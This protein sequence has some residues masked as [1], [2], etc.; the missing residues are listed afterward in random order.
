M[1]ENN[2]NSN[3]EQNVQNNMEELTVEETPVV[4]ETPSVPVEP[5][6]APKKKGKGLKVF[7]LIL[8]ILLVIGGLIFG[9]IKLFKKNTT[10]EDPF[11]DIDTLGVTN[12]DNLDIAASFTDT[13][14]Y[15]YANGAINKDQYLLQLAYSIFEPN[16]LE[17]KYKSLD[18]DYA[19]PRDL[20]EKFFDLNENEV[21][22]ETIKYIFG[23]YMLDFV[24]WDVDDDSEVNKT[25]ANVYDGTIKRLNNDV[26]LYGIKLNKAKLSKEGHFII[27]YSTEGTN[28]AS[29]EAAEIY[30]SYLEE[31]IKKYKKEYGLDFKF[32][33][34][35]WDRDLN[36][37]GITAESKAKKVLEANGIDIKYLD[38]AFPIYLLNLYDSGIP[39]YFS[40]TPIIS[41]ALT[42][43]GN[44]LVHQFKWDDLELQ[45]F[46]SLYGTYSFPYF[47]INS[48]EDIDNVKTIIAHELF[49]HYQYYICGNGGYKA[50]PSGVFTAETT[51]DVASVKCSGIDKVGT[52]IGSH[53]AYVSV[54]KSMENSMD[55]VYSGYGA[56]TFAYNYTEMVPDGTNKTLESLKTTE[57]LKYLYNAS[58]GKYKEV[59]LTTAEKNLTLDYPS[60]LLLPYSPN[61]GFKVFYPGAHDN[62]NTSH[63]QHINYSSMHYYYA[64]PSELSNQKLYLKTRESTPNELT[65]LLFVNE[66]GTKYKKIYSQSLDENFVISFDDWI[67][68][69]ELAFAIVESTIDN[70]AVY[71]YII[72][73]DSNTVTEDVTVTPESLGLK[74]PDN[75][76]KRTHTLMC[77]QVE[78]DTLFKTGYQVLINLDKDEKINNMMLKGTVKFKNYDPENPA[79]KIAKKTAEG[80]MFG[81]KVAYK[82]KLKHVKM[83]TNDKGDTYSIL[84]KVT[85]DYDTAFKGSFEV[86]PTDKQT[87]KSAIEAQGFICE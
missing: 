76:K 65:L 59:L 52:T 43:D 81:M 1:N 69:E 22:N 60:K 2:N 71:Y 11:A 37:A 40:G 30:A 82:E 64:N 25:S 84:F 8:I 33:Q 51:A 61:Y 73:G 77:Y 36:P 44:A 46:K 23:K 45:R 67:D 87:I 58:N 54:H 27:Y 79:Y 72:E 55:Q 3:L 16:K 10:I 28:K 7:I 68:Y 5:T 29:E 56:Y 62:I 6:Q 34:Q 86:E 17:E 85:S 24:E 70:E 39:G 42:I 63:V 12:T 83:Y 13:I 49:H 57:P 4:T 80:L 31:I 53:A 75:S 18:N 26:G 50:C 9:G 38:T 74:K 48:G 21:S 47:V 32:D 20:Y 35:Y 19:N 78:D 14:E 15:D 66:D 41:G